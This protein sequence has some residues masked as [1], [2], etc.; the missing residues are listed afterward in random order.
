GHFVSFSGP[1]QPPPPRG[2]RVAGN[3]LLRDGAPFVPV[4]FTMVAVASPTMGGG[5]AWAAGRLDDASMEQAIAWG[6]NTVRFQVS[7]RGLDPT[8]PLYSDAYVQRVVDAVALARGHGLVVILSVQDQRPSGGSSHAQPSD[9]TIRDWQTLTARFNGDQNVLYEMY[10][11]PQNH[12]TPTGWAVWRDGGPPERNQGTPAVGHQAVLDAIR[13]TGADNVVI[14]D[15]GQF[16]QLLVGVPPLHDPLGQT[17][18]G[19][20]PYL[21]QGLRDPSDWEPGFGF[22]A[23][24][25]PVIATEWAADSKMGFCHPEWAQTAPQ[26]VDFLQA[27]DIGMLAWALDVRDSVVVDSRYTPTS[28]DGFQCG[29]FDNGAGSL[30][31]ARM[32]GWVPHLSGCESGLSDEGVV[33]LPVDIPADGTYRLW[34]QVM[35]PAAG[36]G[37]SLLQVDDGC[38]V[39]AWSSPAPS[40]RWTWQ[41]VGDRLSLS[42]GRH[43][44]RFLGPADGGVDLDRVVLTTDP[45]CVPDGV[46]PLAPC[47]TATTPTSASSSPSPASSASSSTT[48]RA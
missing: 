22:L 36:G 11:E 43:T 35:S 21:T 6:A 14:A 12:A 48:P 17:A 47:L 34:S 27:H 7:Q 8:D 1:A 42:A 24:Q 23:G 13:A 20:H 30:L 37:V 33:A 3:R 18:Y 5:T 38:A 2:V 31:Q 32:P 25:Y 10:N 46:Y 41:E 26:L 16:G 9:A 4:G 44:L 19:V 29:N 39:P 28:L 40:G 15:A 45:G